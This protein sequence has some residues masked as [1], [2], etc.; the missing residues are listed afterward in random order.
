[1]KPTTA[2]K[3]LNIFLPAAPEDFQQA[4]LTHVEFVELQN[5]P[6]QW[7]QDLR[8]HGPHPRAEV[9]RKLGV[10]AAALKRNDM[11]KALTTAEIKELLA[12]QP[13]WLREARTS[14]AQERERRHTANERRA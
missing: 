1:M 14:L 8:A 11:D 2:A 13:Q 6:P 5:N 9:A 3:K 12:N 10:T 4:A 7:L